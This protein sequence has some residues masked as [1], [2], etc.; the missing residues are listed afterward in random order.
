MG[1]DKDGM[2]HSTALGGAVFLFGYV[3]TILQSQR[4]WGIFVKR[5]DG[6]FFSDV[7]SSPSG[8]KKSVDSTPVV[9]HLSNHQ[10]YPLWKCS[11]L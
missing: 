7:N 8:A 2:H 5:G 11:T 3:T 4:R 1:Q 10:G 9:A 6:P